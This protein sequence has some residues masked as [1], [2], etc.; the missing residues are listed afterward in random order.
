MFYNLKKIWIICIIKTILSIYSSSSL[1][2]IVSDAKKDV[3]YLN[4]KSIEQIQAW[5]H[6]E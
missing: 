4:D 3:I 5:K 2:A 6:K 1:A